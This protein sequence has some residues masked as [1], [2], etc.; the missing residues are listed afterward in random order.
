M[1]WVVFSRERDFFKS[2][3]SYDAACRFYSA[4]NADEFNIGGKLFYCLTD[5]ITFE[6]AFADWIFNIYE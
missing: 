5:F 2:F 3:V 4:S 6:H 1:V